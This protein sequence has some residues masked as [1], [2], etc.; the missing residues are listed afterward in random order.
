ME[1]VGESKSA[2]GVTAVCWKAGLS[3]R[4][5]TQLQIRYAF[6]APT[7]ALNPSGGDKF[8]LTPEEMD[9]QIEFF[10]SMVPGTGRSRR[11]A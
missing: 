5:A 6:I 9:W 8:P 3:M 1:K 7:A 4:F 11:R 10:A 2:R